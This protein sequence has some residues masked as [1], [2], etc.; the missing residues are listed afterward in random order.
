MRDEAPSKLGQKKTIK[1]NSAVHIAGTRQCV[2]QQASEWD[3]APFLRVTRGVLLP[4]WMGS[5]D[6]AGMVAKKEHPPTPLRITNLFQFWWQL[7]KTLLG[8]LSC[9]AMEETLLCVAFH[10]S[11]PLLG[12]VA[13]EHPPT[14]KEVAKAHLVGQWGITSSDTGWTPYAGADSGFW[15]GGP[16]G[17]L[18]GGSEPKICLK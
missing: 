17:V 6:V 15:S 5:Q 14:P 10:A 1:S 7:V 13:K 16:S 11:L 9:L 12:M 3:L 2:T 8:M 4:V 18:R